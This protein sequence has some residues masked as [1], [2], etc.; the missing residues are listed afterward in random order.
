[1]KRPLN[2]PLKDPDLK[3]LGRFLNETCVPVS[4][5]SLESLDGLFMP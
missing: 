4:G 2:G 3:R 5:L 1:M